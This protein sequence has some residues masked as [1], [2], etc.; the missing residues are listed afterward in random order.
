MKQVM[1]R[2]QLGKEETVDHQGVVLQYVQVVRLVAQAMV[3]VEDHH[4]SS[5][6]VLQVGRE[7]TVV[8]GLVN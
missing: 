3:Y 5:V 4:L 8:S 2:G 1:G 7:V 6:I